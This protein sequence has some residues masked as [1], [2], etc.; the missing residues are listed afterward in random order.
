MCLTEMW[1]KAIFA[2]MAYALVL[3]CM[4]PLAVWAVVL[5]GSPLASL[6]TP[7]STSDSTVHAEDTSSFH[8]VLCLRLAKAA[9]AVDLA[10][11]HN[12]DLAKNPVSGSDATCY[13]CDFLSSLPL[14]SPAENM[15]TFFAWTQMTALIR[16]RNFSV[17]YVVD[18]SFARGPPV[19]V[20]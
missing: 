2:T 16:E 6:V 5:T 15:S 10:S 7:V 18:R 13:L 20:S 4:M 17:F 1:K 3:K 14:V 9:G 11:P 12:G 8:S 19:A